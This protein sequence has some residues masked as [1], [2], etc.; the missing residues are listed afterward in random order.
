MTQPVP[1]HPAINAHLAGDIDAQCTV[2]VAALEG[3]IR[4]REILTEALNELPKLLAVAHQ[5]LL[6]TMIN[7]ARQGA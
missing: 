4:D 6:A 7:D 2:I 1:Y 3:G 5:R